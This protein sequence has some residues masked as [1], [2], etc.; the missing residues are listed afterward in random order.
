MIS[1]LNR[2]SGGIACCKCNLKIISARFRIKIE[3][4]YF[5]FDFVI[6]AAS[7]SYIPVRRIVY[8]LLTVMISSKIVGLVQRFQF[9]KKEANG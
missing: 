7:L 1:S 3:Y 8:S 6:L 4:V 5:I 2:C 9:P